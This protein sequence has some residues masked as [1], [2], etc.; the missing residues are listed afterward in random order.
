MKA[1][2]LTRYAK[3]YKLEIHNVDMPHPNHSQ[4]LIKVKEAAV[5]PLDSLIGTGSLRLIQNYRLP[6]T[7]GNELTGEIVE[8]GKDVSGFSVNDK[9]YARLPISDIGAFALPARRGNGQA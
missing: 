1:A 5:N 8:V 3:N 6:Q 9:V 7:M 4:A 2:Q